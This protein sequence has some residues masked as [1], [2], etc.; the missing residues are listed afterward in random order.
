MADIAAVYHWSPE[1]M[2]AM[3]FA[4]LLGWSARAIAQHMSK[5][6]LLA[7]IMGVRLV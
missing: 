5:M 2:R 4:E 3:S 1:I 7:S 6:K